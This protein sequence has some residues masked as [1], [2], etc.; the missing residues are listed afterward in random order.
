MNTNS[1]PPGFDALRKSGVLLKSAINS[2][3]IYSSQGFPSD[4]TDLGDNELGFREQQPQTEREPQEM[5]DLSDPSQDWRNLDEA[6]W[7]KIQKRDMDFL[8]RAGNAG[9][10]EVFDSAMI[11]SLLKTNRASAQ[12]SQW[13]PD[14][15]NDLDVKCRL[16]L[17][18]Y[19]HNKD[20]A[21]DYGA[22]ELAEFEDVLLSSIKTDGQLVL[23]LKQRAGESSST[24]IDAF[25]AD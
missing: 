9:S 13:L 3:T 8:V 20:F 16:L 4:N 6:N 7:D 23:F 21:E 12:I 22:D 2:Q 15:V 24:K 10:K 5:A 19:W 25:S 1:L 11:G 18:F 14:L 17:L